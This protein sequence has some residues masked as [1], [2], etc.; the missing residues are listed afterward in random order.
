MIKKAVIIGLLA[1][2][3]AKQAGADPNN[4]G[5]ATLPLTVPVRTW[6]LRG[7]STVGGLADYLLNRVGYRLTVTDPAPQSARQIAMLPIN[8]GIY[9]REVMTVEEI[10][11]YAIGP[12]NKLLIDVPNRLVSFERI[13]HKF[14]QA[15][16]PNTRYFTG[17]ISELRP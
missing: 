4:V 17:R 2:A 9:G 12:N 6:E 16:N 8:P 5:F 13:E 15:E 1:L 14:E 10:L 11:A 7:F 3:S